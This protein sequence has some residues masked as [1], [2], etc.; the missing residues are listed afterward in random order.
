[1]RRLAAWSHDHRRIV[2]ALWAS[3]LLL[4]GGLAA[5]VGTGAVDTFSLPGSESQ[6]AYD[7]MEE[8]FP[9]QSGDSSQIV[10]AAP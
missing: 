4:F 10:F 2:L 5:G 6:R 8:Q 1:M 9:Q 3:M 7:L